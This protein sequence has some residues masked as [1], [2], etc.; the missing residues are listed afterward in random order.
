IKLGAWYIADLSR[1]FRGDM[2]LVLAAYNGGRGNVQQW[3][4]TDQINPGESSISRIPF[5]ET[6][7]FVQK[8]RAYYNIY[9][10]LY[11]E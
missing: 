2:I 5:P 1:E 8:V 6:R 9:M 3:L 4:A 7:L 11:P 10:K